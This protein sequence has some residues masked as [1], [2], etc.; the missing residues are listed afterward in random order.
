MPGFAPPCGVPT[1][2]VLFAHSPAGVGPSPMAR[3]GNAATD[4][5]SA[6]APAT[7]TTCFTLLNSSSFSLLLPSYF[8]YHQYKHTLK[9]MRSKHYLEEDKKKETVYLVVQSVILPLGR[10]IRRR[11]LVEAEGNTARER[12]REGPLGLLE[13]LFL[14]VVWPIAAVLQVLV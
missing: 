2:L 5:I 13:E 4:S 10:E 11:C 1:A 6:E 8:S 9:R 7:A 12:E 3:A 14:F